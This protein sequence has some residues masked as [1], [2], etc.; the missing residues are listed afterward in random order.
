MYA[1]NL[2][3]EIKLIFEAIGEKVSDEEVDEMV[4]MIDPDGDGQVAYAEFYLM[5]SGQVMM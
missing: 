2:A 5:A 1:V 3:K 4:K